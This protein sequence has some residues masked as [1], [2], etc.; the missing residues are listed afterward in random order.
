VVLLISLV[1]PN[2]YFAYHSVAALNYKIA[3]DDGLDQAQIGL[4]FTAYF[5]GSAL[6]SLVNMSLIERFGLKV[7][8]SIQSLMHMSL[9]LFICHVL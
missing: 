9:M 7:L 3:S 8:S 4:L 2:V 6:M 1:C 5:I